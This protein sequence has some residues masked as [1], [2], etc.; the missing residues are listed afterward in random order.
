MKRRTAVHSGEK[1]YECDTCGVVFSNKGS[2][3]RHNRRK[4]GKSTS[5]D[6][7]PTAKNHKC[8]ICGKFSWSTSELKGHMTVHTREKPYECAMYVDCSFLTLAA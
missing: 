2:L 7:V 8:L 3:D 4:H 6:G 1:P 5:S